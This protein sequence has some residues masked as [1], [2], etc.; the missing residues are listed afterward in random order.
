MP[1]SNKGIWKTW[2]TILFSAKNSSLS[3]ESKSRCSSEG[4]PIWSQK[5]VSISSFFLKLYLLLTGNDV[6]YNLNNFFLLLAAVNG[7]RMGLWGMKYIK[8]ISLFL[9]F[10]NPVLLNE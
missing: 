9:Y 2:Q 6:I 5:L 7:G 3:L 10:F 8:S 1:S 4:C